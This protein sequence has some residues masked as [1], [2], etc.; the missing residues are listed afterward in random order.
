MKLSYL[1]LVLC[2]FAGAAEKAFD[3]DRQLHH[4]NSFLD[5]YMAQKF[6]K[7]EPESVA[8]FDY[9]DA[10]KKIVMPLGQVP[11]IFF[12]VNLKVTHIYEQKKDPRHE[13]LRKFKESQDYK[14]TESEMH[15]FQ[16]AS[17]AEFDLAL[18]LDSEHMKANRSLYKAAWSTQ[19]AAAIKSVLSLKLHYPDE[20]YIPLLK[21]IQLL[22]DKKAYGVFVA[23]ERLNKFLAK[24]GVEAVIAKVNAEQK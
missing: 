18:G 1:L 17:F 16:L 22:T 4:L 7:I 5:A 21:R 19:N 9:A 24:G 15:D 6:I 3:P 12:E 23:Q 8:F 11:T 2:G 20:P 13:I 10:D 14:P